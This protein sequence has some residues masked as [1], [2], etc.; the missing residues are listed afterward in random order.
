MGAATAMCAP[1]FVRPRP[2]AL[3]REPRT[4]L[5]H[6]L[7]SPHTDPSLPPRAS[8]VLG[9]TTPGALRFRWKSLIDL[10]GP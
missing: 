2:D 5:A 1:I 3:A 8:L 7:G 4:S 6:G 10:S 9:R